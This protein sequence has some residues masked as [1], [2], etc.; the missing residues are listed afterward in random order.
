MKETRYDGQRLSALLDGRMDEQQR[1]ELLA[2]LAS[3]DEDYLVF[4][5]TATI[6]HELEEEENAREHSAPDRN[7]IPGLARPWP[8]FF[9]RAF[10]W[11]SKQKDVPRAIEPLAR[12]QPPPE[13]SSESTFDGGTSDKSGWETL[14]RE[15]EG[16]RQIAASAGGLLSSSAVA[17]ILQISPSSVTSWLQRPELLAVP[18]AEGQ[19]GFPA[20]QFRNGHVRPGITEVLK[21]GSH[22][23]AWVLLSI[24]IDDVEDGRGGTLL[25]RLDE[26]AVLADVLNRLATY[27]THGA[28]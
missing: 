3:A 24:L 6:L 16:K 8:R 28:A 1:D 13:A 19:L 20:L 11:R 2:Y 14:L 10:H 21:A 4:V 27:G 17:E 5:D 15:K 18:L 25:E 7:V 26:P 22:I 9:E 12:K 23:D